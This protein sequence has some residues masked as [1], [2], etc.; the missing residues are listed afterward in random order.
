VDSTV[1]LWDAS[2][3]ELLNRLLHEARVKGAQFSADGK[4]IL[5]W[6]EDGSVRLWDAASDETLKTLQH[7]GRVFGAQFST[8]GKRILTWSGDGTVRLWDISIDADWPVDQLVL[9]T[10]VET[11]IELTGTGEL[12]TLSVTAWQQKKWCE[13]DKILHELD[14]DNDRITPGQWQTSQRLCR[15]LKER[16]QAGA[17]DG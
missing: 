12:R 17:P 10:E 3:W 7:E 8:D 14:K 11:G 15:E 9:R 16:D 4:R 6:S 1:R 5:T 13:Y 2:S